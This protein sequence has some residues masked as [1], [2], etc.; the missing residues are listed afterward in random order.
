MKYYSCLVTNFLSRIRW[1]FLIFG[2]ATAQ[3]FKP[4]KKTQRDDRY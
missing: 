2:Q 1:L 3:M 4:N